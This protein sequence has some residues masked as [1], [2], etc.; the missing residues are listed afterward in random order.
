MSLLIL[1]HFFGSFLR[2][3]I[4]YSWQQ[5]RP[6]PSPAV[7]LNSRR[8]QQLGIYLSLTRLI[9]LILTVSD[10]ATALDSRPLRPLLTLTPWRE[11]SR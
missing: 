1:N 8:P 3:S 7:I 6:S 11:S 9:C 5:A 4:F 2:F 10:F